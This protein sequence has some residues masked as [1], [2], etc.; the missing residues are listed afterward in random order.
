MKKVLITGTGGSPSTNF[1]RSLRA[2]K[3]K[4]FI[5]G[6]DSDKYYLQRSEADESYLVPSCNHEKYFNFLNYIIEKHNLE[7]M[8]VQN[9]N[10]MKVVSEFRERLNIKLF[11]P[12]KETINCCLNKYESYK[13]W[14]ANKIKVPKTYPLS[15][16]DDLRKAYD[17]LGGKVW[18]REVSGAG[19]RGSLAP[20]DF[21]QAMAWIDFKKGWGKFVAAELL[22]PDSITWMSI[23]KDGEL[24]IA[25][26]RKR[27]YWELG[28]VSPSGISGA[29]GAGV[30]ISDSRLDEIALASI[31]S[32]DTKPNG[33]FSVDLT[34]DF[35]GVPNPTEINI[36]RF[37]T[38]HEFFTQAGLNMPE[39]LIRLAYN[40]PLPRLAKKI[41]PLENGLIW[42]RGMDF[43][44]VLI[45][46][47]KL[48]KDRKIMENILKEL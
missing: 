30:T 11:L 31:K 48:E 42:I 4:I 38:T 14:E 20:E 47:T 43:L 21:D 36:G 24:I 44:P 28:K 37:F 29:T 34:Y 22:S 33:I 16:P 2:M 46:D 41:N 27:L 15:N 7:F 32:I 13:K 10:E 9:D 40:E 25:Q 18:V 5:V 35:S 12:S 45:K 17:I 26:G 39:I 6:T 19:G 23:W 8:H 3:E 1:I